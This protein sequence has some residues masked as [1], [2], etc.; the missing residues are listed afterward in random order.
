MF[1]TLPAALLLAAGIALAPAHAN[2]ASTQPFEALVEVGSGE[3]TW[4]GLQV[5]DARLLSGS[6]EFTGLNGAE[7]LALEITYRRKISSDRLVESTAKEWRRLQDELG[8][9]GTERRQQWLGAVATIWPD[10]APGDRIIARYE[11]GGPTIFYG[12]D[13]LLGVVDDPEFGPAFLGI[14]LHPETR[15]TSL[16]AALLGERR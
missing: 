10:V 8:L 9:P 14:W 5:Y 4:F 11:P 15:D 6:P 2:P 1:R 3:L 13:G 7:P 12:N 16:R